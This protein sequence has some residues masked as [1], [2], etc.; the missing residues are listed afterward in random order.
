MHRAKCDFLPLSPVPARAEKYA[1]QPIVGL[2]RG[3]IQRRI[4][5]AGCWSL[6]SRTV[7][8]HWPEAPRIVN[9]DQRDSSDMSRARWPLYNQR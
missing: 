4:D 1:A 6:Q 7:I 9:L 8:E 2:L 5:G 3:R